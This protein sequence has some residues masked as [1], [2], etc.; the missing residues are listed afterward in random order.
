MIS[1]LVRPRRLS[2]NSRTATCGWGV[3]LLAS[4][5]ASPLI[6]AIT[7]VGL[8]PAA[9]VL[10]T[11]ATGTMPKHPSKTASAT[12]LLLM[13]LAPVRL[14]SI[15]C[16]RRPATSMSHANSTGR[17]DGTLPY[18]ELGQALGLRMALWSLD[19][20]RTAHCVDCIHAPH[21]HLLPHRRHRPLGDLLRSARLPGGRAHPDQRR[22][23]QHLHEPARR[24]RH[25][26]PGADP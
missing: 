11:A 14:A 20:G 26:A 6:P 22:G 10:A 2:W 24:R 21:S 7:S 4:R 12:P 5:S 15:R 9:S 3:W 16:Q 18:S 17:S 1:G 19:I 8:G 13:S 23:R 25:A